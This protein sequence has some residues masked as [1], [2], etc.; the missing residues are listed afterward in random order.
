MANYV[1]MLNRLDAAWAATVKATND[2]QPATLA[3]LTALT[4]QL[5]ADSDAL[6]KAYAS[7]R[8]Q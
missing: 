8:R 1:V 2:P 6:A 3:D 4:D 5:K 7:L